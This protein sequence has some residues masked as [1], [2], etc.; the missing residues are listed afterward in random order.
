MNFFQ[1]GKKRN[2]WYTAKTVDISRGT[3]IEKT[4]FFLDEAG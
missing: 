4:K 2:K 1:L 3:S